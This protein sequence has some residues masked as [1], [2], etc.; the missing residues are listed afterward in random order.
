M[1][2]FPGRLIPV[3]QDEDDRAE[4]TAAIHNLAEP[5]KALGLPAS[6]LDGTA[7]ADA[8]HRIR[9]ELALIVFEVQAD[10]DEAAYQARERERRAR[11]RERR[12]A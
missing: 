7:W 10:I 8:L 1:H 6:Q 2:E 9:G 5:I 11:E 3:A 4:Y 12:A